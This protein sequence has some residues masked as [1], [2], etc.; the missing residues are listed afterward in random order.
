[1]VLSDFNDGVDRESLS[2]DENFQHEVVNGVA[3]HCQRD[4]RTLILN[5]SFVDLALLL[6]NCEISSVSPSK[7]WCLQSFHDGLLGC[8]SILR[9]SSTTCVLRFH[10]DLR[11]LDT[12]STSYSCE[13]NSCNVLR[14]LELEQAAKQETG[15]SRNLATSGSERDTKELSGRR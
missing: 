9:C 7:L 5:V 8:S 4:R 1:M 10:R 3:V 11:S 14:A 6:E 15:S 13:N 12:G 2:G